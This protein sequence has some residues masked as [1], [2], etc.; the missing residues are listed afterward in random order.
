M[1]LIATLSQAVKYKGVNAGG[2]VTSLNQ[3]VAYRNAQPAGAIANIQQTVKTYQ[4]KSV[5]KLKQRVTLEVELSP[6]VQ[7]QGLDISEV[8]VN[9]VSTTAVRGENRTASFDI[10]V[11]AGSVNPNSYI[12]KSVVIDNV[13]LKNNKSVVQRIFT[14]W[15]ETPRYNPDTQTI[16]LSCSN[17][18]EEQI[19]KLS[20]QQIKSKCGGY[21]HEAVFGSE[22]TGHQYASER[23]R[24]IPYSLDYTAKNQ[25]VRI[26]DAPGAVDIVLDDVEDSG[27]S[28]NWLTRQGLVTRINLKLEYRYPRLRQRHR[29]FDWKIEGYNYWGEYMARP[30]SLCNRSMIQEAINATGWKLK[31][32]I[33]FVPLP[34]AGWYDVGGV[35]IGWDP[36]SW[37]RDSDG[38]LTGYT[39]YSDAYPIRAQWEMALRFSQTITETY[40]IT[41]EAPQGL[42]QFGEILGGD[43]SYGV[44]A[45]FDDSGWTEMEAYSGVDPDAVLSPNGDYIIDKTDV[46]GASRTD[47]EEVAK[48]ALALN[49]QIILD[50]FRRNYVDFQLD[51]IR[52]D[53]DLT[54][55]ISITNGRTEIISRVQSVS[56]NYDVKTGL[57]YTRVRLAISLVDS[58]LSVTNT[59]IAAPSIPNLHDQEQSNSTINLGCHLGGSINS[60]EYSDEWSGYITNYY[61]QNGSNVYPTAFAVRVDAIAAVDRDEKQKNVSSTHDVK[62]PIETLTVT[63]A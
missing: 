22:S 18:R 46:E 28:I 1:P 29:S 63:N 12:G 55:T 24:T 30:F 3:L 23:M 5:I 34:P 2:T 17:L 32:N 60:P 53:I 31:D 27:I 45:E 14:G 51:G 48:A 62:I 40:E 4:S 37:R 47:F 13:I 56:F 19:N 42:E 61:I 11:P 39:D 52:S 43:A 26:A 8:V 57:G 59:A 58:G 54:E 16:T 33:D 50:S 35:K 49:R 10:S 21:W 20:N 9:S 25:L 7:L 41:I 44:S 36:K 15:V 6:I 38:K